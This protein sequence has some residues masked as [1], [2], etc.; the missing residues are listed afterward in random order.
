MVGSQYQSMMT[1]CRVPGH[2]S[3]IC[4][5]LHNQVAPLTW[6][7]SQLVFFFCLLLFALASLFGRR[8]APIYSGH[9]CRLFLNNHTGETVPLCT[10][11]GTSCHTP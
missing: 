5:L 10:G 8:D 6:R 4:R 11:E 2:H 1:G 3:T 7:P 9:S